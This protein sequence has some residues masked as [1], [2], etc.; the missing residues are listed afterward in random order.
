MNASQRNNQFD[1]QSVFADALAEAE[2][3]IQSARAAIDRLGWAKEKIAEQFARLEREAADLDVMTELEFALELKL[4]NPNAKDPNEQA[5]SL[6]ANYRR[7]FDLPHVNIG[8]KIRYTREQRR[9]V[10]EILSSGSKQITAVRKTVL[11]K[12]A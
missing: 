10:C 4:E 9:A 12:A 1:P 7:K 3:S 6:L 8:G 5:E 2:A 11:K